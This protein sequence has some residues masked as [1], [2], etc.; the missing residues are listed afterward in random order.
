M[1]TAPHHTLDQLQ[2]LAKKT[3]FSPFS[4]SITDGHSSQT[5]MALRNNR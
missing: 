4:S 1:Y 2:Q 5:K 3:P